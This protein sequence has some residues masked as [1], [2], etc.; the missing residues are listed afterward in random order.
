MRQPEEIDSVQ[1]VVIHEYGSDVEG[2]RQSV[3]VDGDRHT[4]GDATDGQLPKLAPETAYVI[5]HLSDSMT[6]N[7][8][9]IYHR[10]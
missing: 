10:V 2:R 1:L 8:D 7:Y 6:H 9:I 3:E 4:E 5:L